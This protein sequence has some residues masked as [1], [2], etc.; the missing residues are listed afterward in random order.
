MEDGRIER[1]IEILNVELLNDGQ[2]E[3]WKDSKVES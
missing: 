1:W 3:R 2:N